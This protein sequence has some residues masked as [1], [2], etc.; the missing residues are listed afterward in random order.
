MSGVK[1][2]GGV[3][4]RPG[5]TSTHKHASCGGSET[6]LPRRLSHDC[7]F[8]GRHKPPEPQKPAAI[9]LWIKAGWKPEP[10]KAMRVP[11]ESRTAIRRRFALATGRCCVKCEE[12]Q[13]SG[14]LRSKQA[15]RPRVEAGLATETYLLRFPE[16]KMFASG[17]GVNFLGGVASS[18]T[19]QVNILFS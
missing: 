16:I 9:S 13:V 5:D 14:A 11:L 10:P 19:M 18:C 4:G 8:H 3:Q 2:R 7:V 15:P 6:I 17:T 1:R 12:P